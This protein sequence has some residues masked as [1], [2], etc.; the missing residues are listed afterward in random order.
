[1]D[2][3]GLGRDDTVPHCM[4]VNLNASP[5][6]L[7]AT[8]LDVMQGGGRGLASRYSLVLLVV[9]LSLASTL[10]MIGSTDQV[11]AGCEAG[12][13]GCVAGRS[14]GTLETHHQG[15]C[16]ACMA[17]CHTPASSQLTVHFT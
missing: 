7:A 13:I 15:C 2:A 10:L 12:D 9:L 4:S 6:S 5:S 14:V 1:M 3:D 11:T 8:C 17:S 16:G